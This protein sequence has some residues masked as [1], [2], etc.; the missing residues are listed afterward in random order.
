MEE[1]T[2]CG[3]FLRLSVSLQRVVFQQVADLHS[4]GA[5]SANVSSE[6]H[7]FMNASEFSVAVRAYLCAKTG[8]CLSR[9]E[10]CLGYI[11]LEPLHCVGVRGEPSGYGGSWRDGQL[12]CLEKLRVIH[13]F[14]VR[15]FKLTRN[16]RR[17]REKK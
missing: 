16:M 7:N 3:G 17:L 6:Y 1:V 10:S 8:S 9:V 12:A 5:A 13:L 14:S 15:V 2:L 4:D 11:G